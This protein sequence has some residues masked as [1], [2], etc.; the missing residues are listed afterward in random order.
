MHQFLGLEPTDDPHR[1]RLPVTKG[2]CGGRDSIYGGCGLASALEAAEAATGREATWAACHFLR[3]AHLDSTLILHVQVAATGRAVTHAQVVATIEDGGGPPSGEGGG[4]PAFVVP[5]ALG[6]RSF[7]GRHTFTAMP[8]VPPPESCPPRYIRAD[9]QG[10]FRARITERAVTDDPR[11]MF[12][13]PGGRAALWTRLPDGV[14][15]SASALATLGDAVSL[16]VS[17]ALTPDA[18]A[19]SIDNT[20]RVI[21]PLAC[22]WV[23]ADIEV[24][25]IDRGFAHGTVNLWSPDG[26]LLAVAAQTGVVRIRGG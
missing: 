24:R 16:G 8:T 1:W 7:P 3:P 22:E 11:G 13:D 18:Q 19:P 14:P 4:L 26:D 21:R 15:A 20:L 10:G 9:Y 2:I 6:E 5:V 25:A 23:L 17:A 12:H